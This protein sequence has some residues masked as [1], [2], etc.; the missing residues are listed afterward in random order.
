MNPL[1]TIGS[2]RPPE[3]PAE[4]LR[5]AATIR[6]RFQML[7]PLLKIPRGICKFKTWESLDQW[8]DERR[9]LRRR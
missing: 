7:T 5:V 4:F 8:N 6:R 3:T 1:K 2:R 9:A